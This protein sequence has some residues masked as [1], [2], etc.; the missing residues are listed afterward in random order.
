MKD[1]VDIFY[2]FAQD[3]QYD[4]FTLQRMPALPSAADQFVLSYRVSRR[5]APVVGVI[6]VLER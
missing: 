3:L 4:P 6:D 2:I 5:Q 1:R